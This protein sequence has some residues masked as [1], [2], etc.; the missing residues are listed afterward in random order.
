MFVGVQRFFVGS[1]KFVKGDQKYLCRP[2]KSILNFVKV[3]LL[4]SS[5]MKVYNE[6]RN[7]CRKR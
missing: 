5:P 3:S 4:H 2:R 7:Q 6:I 1:F